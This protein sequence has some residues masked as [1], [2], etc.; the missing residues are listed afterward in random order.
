MK[1]AAPDRCDSLPD[2]TWRKGFRGR[3]LR[4]YGRHSRDLPWRQRRDPYAIWLSEIMLQQ[5]QVATVKAYFERF[6]G[7]LPT[8]EALAEADEQEVLRLWEG[9]GYYRRARQLHRAAKLI[10]AEHGG[11]FPRDPQ[12]VRQLPGVGRYT[13]GAILSIAFD[14]R[15][16]IL[17]GNTLRLL[18]RLLAYRGDPRSAAGQ[19]VLWAMAEAV[20]PRRGAGRVN[21]AL[22]E[23]GSEVCVVR[24]PRCEV[25]PVAPLCRARQQGRE[26]EIP[27]PK[28]RQRTKRVREAAVV[29]RKGGRVFLLRRPDGGRWAGLWDF[30]RFPIHGQTPAEIR[31][32]MAENVKSLTGFAIARCRHVT[33]LVHSVTRFRITLECYAAEHASCEGKPATPLE[34]CWVRPAQLGEYPLS[35]TG[36]KLAGLVQR[37]GKGEERRVRLGAEK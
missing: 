6:V 3:L 27:P 22:M 13:A 20:L 15:E 28:A 32:E 4:W 17:E 11:Q 10:V 7:A 18:S 5:T 35:A 25:C 1:H 12:I 14:F 9:L 2:A 30:P 16:P 31:R 34:M 36:R 26:L 29:V 21:Q 23:L 19:R 33:T 37:R 8:I 24:S